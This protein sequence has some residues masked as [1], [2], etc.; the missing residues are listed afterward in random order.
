MT[1]H[2]SAY[3]KQGALVEGSQQVGENRGLKALHFSR[4]LKPGGG[5]HPL[6]PS[7]WYKRQQNNCLSY[8]Q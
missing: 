7:A 5:A 1:F 3:D 2:V 4:T 6:W 8:A